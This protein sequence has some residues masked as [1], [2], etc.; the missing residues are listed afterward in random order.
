M[1]EMRKKYLNFVLYRQQFQG[2]TDSFSALFDDLV[3]AEAAMFGLSV[4]FLKQNTEV[5]LVQSQC[6]VG[7]KGSFTNSRRFLITV[8]PPKNKLYKRNNSGNC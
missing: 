5:V 4:F 3:V 7:Y 8:M 2:I 6:Q 1:I